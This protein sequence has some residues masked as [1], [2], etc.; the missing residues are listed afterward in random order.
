VTSSYLD[1]AP[2]Y[3]SSDADQ[4]K[5]RAFVDGKLKP[6]C[7][8]ED[9]VLGFPP[10]VSVFLVCFNRFHNYV[11]GE[12]AAINEGGR[13]TP[14]NIKTLEQSMPNA[15][16]IDIQ[17]GFDAALAK[18]DNDLFQTGKLYSAKRTSD[19]GSPADCISILS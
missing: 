15:S 8:Y 9:R 1:L 5:V 11:V 6:D 7:F 14:P 2:L 19:V 16:A 12:L 13:F 18:R 10:G 3:G 4:K 17:K